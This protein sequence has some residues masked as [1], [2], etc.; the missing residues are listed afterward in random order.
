MWQ[1]G[2][3]SRSLRLKPQVQLAGKV[4]EGVMKAVN[5]MIQGALSF[6]YINRLELYSKAI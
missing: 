3:H 6:F 4:G 5:A 2:G 1:S